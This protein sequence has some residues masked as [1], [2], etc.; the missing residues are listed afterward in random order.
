MNT[1]Q[2]E[3]KERKQNAALMIKYD[4]FEK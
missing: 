1:S 3:E 2:E 4:A